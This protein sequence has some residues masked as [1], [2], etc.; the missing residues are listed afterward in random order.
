MT[1]TTP[2]DQATKQLSRWKGFSPAAKPHVTVPGTVQ[3]VINLLLII[4][5]VRDLRRRSASEINGNK[6]VWMLAAFAPPVGPIVYFL[7]GRKHGAP[8]GG[9]DVSDERTDE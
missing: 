3:A 6:K 2:N 7:F 9:M 5:A 8:A 4:W 1:E